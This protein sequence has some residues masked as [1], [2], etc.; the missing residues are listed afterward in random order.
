MIIKELR[1]KPNREEEIQMD[2]IEREAMEYIRTLFD[3]NADGHGTDHTMRVWRNAMKI[4]DG[5][6][7]CDRNTVSLAAL[8]HDADDHKLFTT[9]NN[10]NARRFLTEHLVPEETAE[11]I[12]PLRCAP[13][14]MTENGRRAR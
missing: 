7:G 6:P 5:E 9:E 13:V 2:G 1:P 14:E 3:G 4:A 8:L 11:K 12:S 10:A